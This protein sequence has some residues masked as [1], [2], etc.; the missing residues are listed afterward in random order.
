MQFVKNKIY[1]RRAIHEEIGGQQQGGISNPRR[2]PKVPIFS[3][4][5]GETYGYNDGWREDGYFL[6][7]GEGQVGGMRLKSGNLAI[8]DYE[9]NGK[10]INLFFDAPERSHVIYH[11]EMRCVD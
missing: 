11:G 4:D 10:T 3:G 7:T 5:Q 2:Q 9:A 1:R 8:R 6:Y